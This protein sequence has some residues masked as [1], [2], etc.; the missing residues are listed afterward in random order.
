M[1]PGGVSAEVGLTC[2]AG[3][4]TRGEDLADNMKAALDEPDV[5]RKGRALSLGCRGPENR[6]G[7][8]VSP[9]SRWS[10]E[11]VSLR[12]PKTVLPPPALQGQPRLDP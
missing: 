12:E 8:G 10:S 1:G 4:E 7:V 9:F 11:G 2:Q 3:V 6:G 5:S